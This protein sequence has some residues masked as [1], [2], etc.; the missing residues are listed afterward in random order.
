MAPTG[1]PVALTDLVTGSIFEFH[2]T[3]DG[4]TVVFTYGNVSSDAVL[5]KNFR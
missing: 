3:A 1:D 2:P 4:K 5:V